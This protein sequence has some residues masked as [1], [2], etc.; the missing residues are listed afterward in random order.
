M[1]LKN[2]Y[3]LKT[4]IDFFSL[5]HFLNVKISIVLWGRFYL[6]ILIRVNFSKSFKD[7]IFYFKESE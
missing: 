6:N 5:L 1:C 4:Q 7:K 2:K 3:E